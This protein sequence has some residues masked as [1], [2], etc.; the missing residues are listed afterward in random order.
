MKATPDIIKDK[1]IIIV[2]RSIQAKVINTDVNIAVKP[3]CKGTKTAKQTAQTN[4]VIA[5]TTGYCQEM[6]EPHA[7]HLPLCR[8][9]ETNGIFLYQGIIVLQCGQCDLGLNI[10]SSLGRR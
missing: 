1:G 9:N 6:D 10:D 7:A 5:S 2:F 8:I 4:P 3:A